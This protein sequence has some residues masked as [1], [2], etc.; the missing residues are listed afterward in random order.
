MTLRIILLLIASLLTA[1]SV[2]AESPRGAVS[3]VPA[4]PLPAHL[5]I[6]LAGD[7][8][9]STSSGWG[10]GFAKCLNPNAQCLDL[11][12]NGRSSKSFINEGQWKK[13]LAAQPDVVLIQFGHNDQPNK[14]P[15]RA[16]DPQT[17]YKQYLTQY[18]DESRAAGARPVLVTSLSRRTW[19]DDGK[20]HSDLTPWVDAVKELGRAKNVPVIDLHTLSIA[21]YEKIGRDECNALSATLA[22]GGIDGTH[23]NPKGADVI[24][25]IVADH[26]KSVLPELADRIK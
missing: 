17:T 18:I 22:G 21:L 24:G 7:S 23:L 1:C 4:K 25:Q 20:I 12:L 6:V 16:T 3:N 26:L 2:P 10:P 8:T 5:R 9:V 13:C 19:G 11:A 14:G 15:D